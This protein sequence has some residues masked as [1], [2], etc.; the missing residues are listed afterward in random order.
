[1][2]SDGSMTYRYEFKGLNETI[3][4][5]LMTMFVLIPQDVPKTYRYGLPNFDS[6]YKKLNYK[7]G[8]Q[9]KFSKK[10]FSY[11]LKENIF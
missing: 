5:D 4:N 7:F 9:P 8:K 6:K 10:I 2:V 11:F 3:A 1:M